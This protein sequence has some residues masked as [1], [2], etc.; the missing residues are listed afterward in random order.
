MHRQHLHA[1]GQPCGGF[2][3]RRQ[4]LAIAAQEGLP[5]GKYSRPRLKN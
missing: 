5:P 1:H 3:A 4:E 2:A